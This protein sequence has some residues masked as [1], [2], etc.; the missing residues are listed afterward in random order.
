MAIFK[1]YV[2]L[3]DGVFQEESARYVRRLNRSMYRKKHTR[4]WLAG[5][6]PVAY[7]WRFLASKFPIAGTF[8]MAIHM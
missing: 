5:R 1:S 2:E 4:T 8:P 6:F 7:K 3:P